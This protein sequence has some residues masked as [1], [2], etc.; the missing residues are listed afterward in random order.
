MYRFV[1]KKTTD[2]FKGIFHVLEN[3]LCTLLL[4]FVLASLPWLV[5][6]WML[7]LANQ[8]T[9]AKIK[10]EKEEVENTPPIKL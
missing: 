1:I 4:P 2:F 10:K 8:A 6:F 3:A 9:N 5:I 7:E